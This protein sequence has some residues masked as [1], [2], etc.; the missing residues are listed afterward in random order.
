MRPSGRPK[1]RGAES[2]QPGELV[3]DELGYP[4]SLAFGDGDGFDRCSVYVTQLME[5]VV[6]R[7]FI[8]APGAPL[9]DGN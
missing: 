9:Y 6:W 2:L 8:G 7:V 3:V 5:P 4:A 1:R